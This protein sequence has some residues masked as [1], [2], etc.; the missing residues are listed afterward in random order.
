MLLKLQT[1][2][3]LGFF[4]IARVVLYKFALR[5][6][7]HPVIF[8][9]K[10]IGG[11]EFFKQPEQLAGS[12]MKSLNVW[13]NEG[14]YFSWYKVPLSG[15]PPMWQTNPFSG[16][17][18][19]TPRLPWWELPD[20]GLNIGDIKTI[21]EASRFDWVLA[22]ATRAKAGDESAIKQ[23][24]TWLA[25][26]CA[27]NPSYCGPNW[28]C[29]QEA[30]IRVLHLAMAAKLLGQETM[31][32]ALLQL[33]TAHLF[34]ISPTL[35]YA[36]AQDNNHGTSEAAALYIGGSWCKKH[37]VPQG[38]RWAR[39]GR[40]LLEN[41]IQYLIAPDGSFSQYSLNYHRVLLDTLSMAEIWRRWIDD[42]EFSPLFYQ[43][44]RA[45][46]SWLYA[47]VDPHSGDGPN[48]GGNDGARLLPVAETDYRDYRPSVQ[49]TMALFY[50]QRAYA[51]EGVY[52]SPLRWYGIPLPSKCADKPISRQFSDGGYAVLRNKAMVAILKYPQYRFRPR[53]CDALH[54][55]LWKG[56]DNILRDGG[57]YRY[58]A[59]LHWQNYFTGAPGH[60]TIEFD[61]REQ[62]PRLGRFLRGAWLSARDIK[63]ANTS[64]TDISASAGY[65][66]W[67]GAC[68]HRE[69][70][71]HLHGIE[72]KDRVRGFASRAVLRWRLQPGNWRLEGK[73]VAGEVCTLQIK[74][75][76]PIVRFELVNGWE[77]RYYYK[78][79]SLPV[80]EVE[81]Q[82]P[83]EITMQLFFQKNRSCS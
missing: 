8:V 38:K 33:I 55:D 45:A 79:T 41:R 30:S 36:I 48:L 78:K 54:L 29:G 17:T 47:M 62:M 58:N 69:V 82:H 56:S 42:R 20:F 12:S 35:S 72:V 6:R 60:N 37:G 34:R 53:H 39:K 2:W 15:K 40:Q 44:T 5:W 22:H 25:D 3:R 81:V 65:C 74:A 24:N 50:K 14:M 75:S 1:L 80:L 68:H 46:T 49:L 7:V 76:V 64:E 70:R 32:P 16:K 10:P 19:D 26:W 52:N 67:K 73:S 43:R 21:W 66:D 4:N 71:L 23:L 61:G 31:C 51:A 63:F 18:I 9:K 11:Q 27:K 57:S 83:G 59:E 77:S 28:K 13:N